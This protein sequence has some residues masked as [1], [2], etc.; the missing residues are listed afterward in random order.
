[1]DLA[2]ALGPM[3]LV[4]ER[5]KL[6][7][8]A[9][10]QERIA[11]LP[12]ELRDLVRLHGRRGVLTGAPEAAAAVDEAW[13]TDALGREQL[14]T[15]VGARQITLLGDPD[16]GTQ[17]IEVQLADGSTLRVSVQLGES[18]GTEDPSQPAPERDSSAYLDALGWHVTIQRGLSWRAA[19]RE[20]SGH[21]AVIV[22]TAGDARAAGV[23]ATDVSGFR[24]YLE[25]IRRSGSPLP[26]RQYWT[27]GYL[28]AVVHDYD[29]STTWLSR[30][31]LKRELRRDLLP[32]WHMAKRR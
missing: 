25:G 16:Y 30:Y 15:W 20:L 28:Q 12:A 10:H 19:G 6:P 14:R 23:D 5:A 13:L 31:Q 29:T 21:L 2:D 8:T 27:T 1:R 9:G 18:R 22:G 17:R 24:S 3:G 4:S 32:T 26:W 7:G 11:M